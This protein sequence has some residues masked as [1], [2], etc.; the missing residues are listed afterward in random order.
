MPLSKTPSWIGHWNLLGIGNRRIQF[1][2]CARHVFRDIQM[3]NLFKYVA[4][5]LLLL[6]LLV[7][8]KK[9]D[10]MGIEMIQDVGGA[11]DFKVINVSTK[12]TLNLYGDTYIG[13]TPK[14]YVQ[15]NHVIKIVFLQSE[16]YS[17]YT[18]ETIFKLHDG[19][20]I[21][22]RSEYEYT[23]QDTE[24]GD[25]EVSLS[26]NAKEQT[27]SASGIFILRVVE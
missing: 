13:A 26:A 12:D 9:S 20:W 3:K 22:N 24:I 5:F 16:K 27:I 21:T 14:L 17:R 4:P 11:G 18:F 25:Y 1:R 2:S 15:N 8:C 10:S 6:C 19:T 7:A 23:I